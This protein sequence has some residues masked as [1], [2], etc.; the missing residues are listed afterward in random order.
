MK[1]FCPVHK[2][3]FATPR[4]N[5]IRCENK[6]HLLG[7]LDF[8]GRAEG[9]W[10]GRWQYCCN[11]EHFWPSDF[12]DE[13][14]PVCNRQISMRY[15]CDR[16][17]TFSLESPTPASV[18]SFSITPEGIPRPSCPGCLQE[19]VTGVVLH[20]HECADLGE[21]FN[22]A[23]RSCPI[24]KEPIGE[25]PSFPCRA[26]ECLSRGKSNRQLKLDYEKDLLVEAEDGEFVLIPLGGA[27]NETI[28]I[29]KLTD[30]TNKQEFYDYYQDYYR[31]ENPSA[32]KVTI[33]DPAVVGQVEGGWKL[34]EAGLLEI[35]KE[36]L[37]EPEES[38]DPNRLAP[39]DPS[40]AKTE[41]QSKCFSCGAVIDSE[42]PAEWG[43]C[44]NCGEPLSSGEDSIRKVGDED[45]LVPS[46]PKQTR[47]AHPATSSS[48]LS[49][50]DPTVAEPELAAGKVNAGRLALFGLI[51]LVAIG[52]IVWLLLRSSSS[53]VPI[54]GANDQTT[55]IPQSPSHKDTGATQRAATISPADSEFLTLNERRRHA[56]A[57]QHAEIAGALKVAEARYPDDYRFPYEHAKMEVSDQPPHDE[58]IGLL[59]VAGKKAIDGGRADEMLSDLVKEEGHEFGGFSRDHRRDWDILKEA[60]RKRDKSALE[61][62][63]TH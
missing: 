40:P 24:C 10:E 39:E 28:V 29:P 12:A 49:I 62:R 43:F 60:L 38:R 55:N 23:L 9:A 51:G 13:Q 7:K 37:T 17:Y 1:V 53:A 34:R 20:E 63:H 14:C 41:V 61:V 56:T 46:R 30:F 4:R 48:R 8:E 19:F 27:V 22:T 57:A 21:G 52:S 26:V 44:W 35:R 6:N 3:S 58:V 36:S 59:F 45:T 25:A 32:G 2:K 50:L 5:P 31:C 18:K 16:C 33:I 15:L 42:H 54:S 11:C 47:A